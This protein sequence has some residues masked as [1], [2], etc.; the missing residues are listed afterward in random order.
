MSKQISDT[1]NR[2]AVISISPEMIAAGARILEDT[3]DALP[4]LAE[5]TAARVFEAMA[6]LWRAP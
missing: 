2:Q 3:Y 5:T 6:A 4:A 1:P